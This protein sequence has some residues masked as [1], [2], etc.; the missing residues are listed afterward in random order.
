MLVVL[1]CVYVYVYVCPHSLLR[2]LDENDRL[3]RENLA[4]QHKVHRLQAKVNLYSGQSRN[5]GGVWSPLKAGPASPTK[6]KRASQTAATTR[7]R[8]RRAPPEGNPY[9]QHLAASKSTAEPEQTSSSGPAR[10]SADGIDDSRSE[11]RR[12][13]VSFAA[14]PAAAMTATLRAVSPIVPAAPVATAKPASRLARP[15][16]ADNNDEEL[17][18][19]DKHKII[20]LGQRMSDTSAPNNTTNSNTNS[21]KEDEDEEATAAA[22][23]GE[24]LSPLRGVIRRKARPPPPAAGE[25]EQG[26]S[27]LATPGKAE[28]GG[29]GGGGT[30]A[31]MYIRRGNSGILGLLTPVL[32]RKVESDSQRKRSH[33]K[34]KKRANESAADGSSSGGN[35]NSSS[36]HRK[37]AEVDRNGEGAVALQKERRILSSSVELGE[38]GDEDEEDLQARL[39]QE[40]AD[41]RRIQEERR[42]LTAALEQQMS[43]AAAAAA[44][45]EEKKVSSPSRSRSRASNK[46][47]QQQPSLSPSRARHQDKEDEGEAGGGSTGRGTSAALPSVRSQEEEA[48]DPYAPTTTDSDSRIVFDAAEKFSS[49]II[50]AAKEDILSEEALRERSPGHSRTASGNGRDVPTVKSRDEPTKREKHEPANLTYSE[51]DVDRT[52]QMYSFRYDSWEDVE[53]ISFDAEKKLHQCILQND[54]SQQ[55]FDLKKKPI[56][57]KL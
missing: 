42:L 40:M 34:E 9:V 44:A 53:I 18:V 50:A 26:D 51:M 46:Q 43:L 29:G 54:K 12:A 35:N 4:L 21:N 22:A 39:S 57:S 3:R 7:R 1:R 30:A 48:Y 19:P 15:A 28:A 32:R 6:M 23:A 41:L 13:V 33:K 49:N 52:I 20:I 47:Q 10:R 5:S 11:P 56:R 31:D 25:A 8:R 2:L 45:A 17:Y 37:G 16:R 38:A 55:W 24:A 36:K 14:E 27:P